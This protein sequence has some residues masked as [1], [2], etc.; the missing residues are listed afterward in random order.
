[1]DG[2]ITA[3]QRRQARKSAKDVDLLEGGVYTGKADTRSIRRVLVYIRDVAMEESFTALEY[4]ELLKRQ[5]SQSARASIHPRKVT[6]QA[7]LVKELQREVLGLLSTFGMGDSGKLDSWKSLLFLSQGDNEKVASFAQRF[8]NAYTNAVCLGN[9]IDDSQ[10]ALQFASALNKQWSSSGATLIAAGVTSLSDLTSRLV[11]EER[12][13]RR[14][15]N[16]KNLVIGVSGGNDK[17]SLPK[18]TQD[19][20]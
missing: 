6:T 13:F 8:D 20:Q 4:R 3:Q 9:A 18:A 12:L 17:A 19:V 5:I 15:T 2:P 10:A 14:S 7:A 1:V 16:V 11:S